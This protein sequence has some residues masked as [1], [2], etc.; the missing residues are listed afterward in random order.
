[1][2][3][4]DEIERANEMYAFNFNKLYR[5]LADKQDK[6]LGESPGNPMFTDDVNLHKMPSVID[7]MY[8]FLKVETASHYKTMDSRFNVTNKLVG[9]LVDIT[10]KMWGESQAFNVGDFISESNSKLQDAITESNNEFANKMSEYQNDMLTSLQ[11]QLDAIEDPEPVELNP[12]QHKDFKD[13]FEKVAKTMTKVGSVIGAGIKT[14]AGAFTD[15]L[16]TYG[17]HAYDNEFTNKIADKIESIESSAGSGV[18]KLGTMTSSLTS[19]LKDIANSIT[20]GMGNLMDLYTDPKIQQAFAKYGS[21]GI[22]RAA[23]LFDDRIDIMKEL[24]RDYGYSEKEAYKIATREMTRTGTR[25]YSR[26]DWDTRFGWQRSDIEYAR[27][28]R[29]KRQEERRTWGQEALLSSAGIFKTTKQ[30]ATARDQI[31][32]MSRI[33]PDLNFQSTEFYRTMVSVFDDTGKMSKEVFEEIRDLS[34]NLMVDPQTL[35]SIGDTYTKYIKLM[36]KGGIGFQKQMTNVLKVTSKLEDQFLDSQGIMGEVNEIGFTMLSNMSDDLLTKTQLYARELGMSITEFQKTARTDPSKMAEM[37]LGAKKGY[38][39]RMGIDA[40]GDIG[41]REMAL[42]Q[43]IGITGFESITDFLSQSQ[44]DLS[45]ADEKLAANQGIETGI[46]QRRQ[47]L[48]NE[49]WERRLEIIDREYEYQMNAWEEQMK[50][51]HKWNDS[52]YTDWEKRQ[53]EMDK[54]LLEND[55]LNTWNNRL[56]TAS[57]GLR[58]IGDVASSTA[59]KIQAAGVG[60]IDGTSNF[61]GSLFGNLLGKYGFKILTKGGGGSSALKGVTLAGT[62][63]ALTGTAGAVSA[64]YGIHKGIQ[65]YN[66]YTDKS[67]SSYSKKSAMAGSVGAGMAVGGGT[68]ALTGSL[69]VLAGANAWNPVGWGLGIAALGIGVMTT[70]DHLKELD[71]AGDSL[72]QTFD[73]NTM[74]YESQLPILKQKYAD[75]NSALQITTTTLSENTREELNNLNSQ[76]QKGAI[77]Q[78]TYNAE[79][80]KL[81][82]TSG[83]GALNVLTN[84]LMNEDGTVS[85]I[86]VFNTSMQLLSNGKNGLV[87]TY[88]RSLEELT[89]ATDAQRKAAFG[90]ADSYSKDLRNKQIKNLAEDLGVAMA[91]KYGGKGKDQSQLI[92]DLKSLG[93]KQKDI[94]WKM[95]DKKYLSKSDIE[96]FMRSSLLTKKVKSGGKG[97]TDINKVAKRYGITGLTT[98]QQFEQSREQRAALN[99]YLQSDEFKQVAKDLKSGSSYIP[100]KATAI[101]N[102]RLAAELGYTFDDIE[103]ISGR[104]KSDFESIKGLKDMPKYAIG[105]AFIPNDQIAQVHKG[106]RIIPAEDN[107]NLGKNIITI[108]D[109]NGLRNQMLETIQKSLKTVNKRIN[110]FNYDSNVK[111]NAINSHATSIDL[112]NFKILNALNSLSEGFKP[113]WQMVDDALNGDKASMPGPGGG[114]FDPLDSGDP[115]EKYGVTS[116]F[117]PRK[118][119]TANASSY[120]KGTDYGMPKG[121][122]IPAFD[123]G[124]VVGNG[125]DSTSGNYVVL[126]NSKGYRFSF[127]HLNSKSPL[128]LGDSV[129][130]GSTIGYSGNTGASTGPHLHLGIK[131]P[132]GQFIDPQ[133]YFGSNPGISASVSSASKLNELLAKIGIIQLPTD[134][135]NLDLDGSQRN[136]ISNM[137]PF[138]MIAANLL[139]TTPGTLLAQWALESGWGTSKFART[140]N[141]FAGINAIDSDPNKATSYKTPADFAKAYA[142]FIGV[143]PDGTKLNTSYVR[144][145]IL[146]TFGSTYYSILK[147]NGYATDPDYVSKLTA[148]YN[149]IGV[150]QTGLS[151][152]P[153]DNYF[154]LLHKDERVLNPSEAR[155]WSNIQESKMGN[156][157][158]SIQDV[159][160]Y[161]DTDAVVDSISTLTD[162]VKEIH[163]ILKPKSTAP[164]QQVVRP[165]SNLITQYV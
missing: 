83:N 154:A 106:E 63:A 88:M 8:G 38:A 65:Y 49:A 108:V 80:L 60:L 69:G 77:D 50:T 12:K 100:N 2:G 120:H 7:N 54:E 18:K 4:M 47:E 144:S 121:T 151:K 126:E 51:L 5:G 56:K 27:G 72:K 148:I 20:G 87:E 140:R 45:R 142:T 82:D 78:Q 67:E 48:E 21:K 146:G 150:H 153:Y 128:K 95:G 86:G 109:L 43:Q 122:A 10:Y 96:V 135:N 22:E 15:Q 28:I 6:G 32:E 107:K 165:R 92:K 9:E 16:L 103:D 68:A 40:S 145:G 143:R 46:L 105:S 97:V 25:D 81:A 133:K 14:A 24:I 33:M 136:F 129:K 30:I 76:L 58:D 62:G 162:V 102:L 101:E 124:I 31:Y 1:M 117:G 57:N 59:T 125:Y 61:L 84:T 104:W 138:A 98:N 123:N 141:N 132:K 139:G 74:Y 52:Y 152:V 115:Y 155:L 73:D 29:R 158:P 70:V 93:I 26:V 161:V 41:E 130:P 164:V 111:L 149:S 89:K 137:M 91:T 99:L 157:E 112:Y 66:Q 85:N 44:A 134:I 3:L 75:I 159:T 113:F 118:K 163:E 79:V 94:D 42:L 64:G 55:A 34:K 127:C 17:T 147:K 116:S 114:L 131:N 19:G 11:K 160:V 35:T 110:N 53:H 36:T 37:L 90:A 23:E 156:Y 39:E 71:D 13:G 119:P